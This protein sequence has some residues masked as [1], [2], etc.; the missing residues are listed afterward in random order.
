MFCEAPGHKVTLIFSVCRGYGEKGGI[1]FDFMDG[2]YQNIVYQSSRSVVPPH[3]FVD[4]TEQWYMFSTTITPPH[5]SPRHQPEGSLN[6]RLPRGAGMT[7]GLTQ[8]PCVTH[9]SGSRPPLSN[10]LGRVAGGAAGGGAASGA[11]AG[12]RQVGRDGNSPRG[13]PSTS[14]L[15][16]SDA[17]RYNYYQS[18]F[19]QFASI[20]KQCNAADAIH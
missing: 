19:T 6:A 11:V 13:V 2:T 5:H 9:S 1:N 18:D 12:R 3:C 16:G 8:R 17:S 14:C 15:S 4:I 7:R 20:S 10:P